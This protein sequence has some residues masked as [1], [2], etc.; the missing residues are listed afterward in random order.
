[1]KMTLEQRNEKNMKD[2]LNGKQVLFP[3]YLAT[4][5]EIKERKDFEKHIADLGHSYM[6]A[7]GNGCYY[8]WK[9]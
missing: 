3:L 9:K 6:S 4:Q 7:T 2:F 8:I 1:M 5:E